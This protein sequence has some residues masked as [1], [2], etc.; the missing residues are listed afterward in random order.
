[1]LN[2]DENGYAGLGVGETIEGDEF[3]RYS[4]HTFCVPMEYLE[5]SQT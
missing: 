2:I 4:G 5:K 1:M 3:S